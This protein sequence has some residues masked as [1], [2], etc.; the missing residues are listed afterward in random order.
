MKKLLFILLLSSYISFGQ[1][2]FETKNCVTNNAQTKITM[3][4]TIKD[5][6]FISEITDKSLI[7]RYQKS[8][9]RTITE[10][11]VQFELQ[12]NSGYK[13]YIFKDEN[14]RVTIINKGEEKWLVKYELK[15]SFTGKIFEVLYY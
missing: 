3:K 7:K 13:T 8:G 5:S 11:T 2:S 14:K 9:I 10:E 1:E 12:T 4:W 6:K 15:D